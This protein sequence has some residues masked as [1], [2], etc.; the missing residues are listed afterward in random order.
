[1]ATP[2]AGKMRWDRLILT[3]LLLGAIGFAVYWY[4]LR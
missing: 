3:L 2:P 1:M 4:A